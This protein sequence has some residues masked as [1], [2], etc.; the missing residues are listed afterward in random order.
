MRQHEAGRTKY[1]PQ[2]TRS[3]MGTRQRL[4]LT[5]SPTA[6][7]MWLETQHQ[8]KLPV[9]SHLGLCSTVVSG[10]ERN[11]PGV[12]QRIT[13]N[14]KYATCKVGRMPTVQYSP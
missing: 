10:E 4:Q 13:K 12:L 14:A 1:C 11:L 7:L 8:V 5:L 3:T 6:S 9:P 2:G